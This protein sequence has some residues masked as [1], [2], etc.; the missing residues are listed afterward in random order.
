MLAPRVLENV[1][2]GWNRLFGGGPGTIGPR[3][4]D[5]GWNHGRLES[6]F[7][8]LFLGVYAASD[9][10]SV[11]VERLDGRDPT[12]ITIC[13]TTP[14]GTERIASDIFNREL[15]VYLRTFPNPGPA[16]ISVRLKGVNA[17]QKLEYQ[18]SVEGQPNW[19]QVPTGDDVA[20]MGGQALDDLPACTAEQREDW[21]FVSE[22]MFGVA[23]WHPGGNEIGAAAAKKLGA[24][25]WMPIDGFR[26]TLCGEVA[27]YVHFAGVGYDHGLSREYDLNHFVIP[28]RAFDYLLEFPKQLWQS[29][30]LAGAAFDYVAEGMA[31]VTGGGGHPEMLRGIEQ[32]WDCEGT[33]DCIETEVTANSRFLINPYFDD[34]KSALEGGPL[35]VYGPW[36]TE[37]SHNNRPEIHP[38]ELAWWRETGDHDPVV[39]AMIQD[40]SERYGARSDYEPRE[41]LRRTWIGK[42]QPGEFW[43]A[44]DADPGRPA[45]LTFEDVLSHEVQPFEKASAA[46]RYTMD[47]RLALVVNHGTVQGLE[48]GLAETSCVDRAN[49]RVLG[50]VMARS[51]LGSGTA[52]DDVGFR[53]LRARRH[54]STPGPTG[55]PQSTRESS[56]TTVQALTAS[57]LGVGIEPPSPARLRKVGLVGD[58]LMRRSGALTVDLRSFEGAEPG[59]LRTAVVLGSGA[60][61]GLDLTDLGLPSL[62]LAPRLVQPRPES[63]GHELLRTAPSADGAAP[64]PRIGPRS[65][66]P[67]PVPGGPARTLPGGLRP[68]IDAKSE[69]SEQA[70]A[71]WGRFAGQLVGAADFD[72]GR[73]ERR[74]EATLQVDVGYAARRG[75]GLA[76]EDENAIAE[77]INDEIRNWE[78]ERLR[79]LFGNE[80][81]FDV[82]WEVVVE[83]VAT[84]VRLPVSAAGLPQKARIVRSA[85]ERESQRSVAEQLERHSTRREATVP[86]FQRPGLPRSQP[87]TSSSVRGAAGEGGF[88]DGMVGRVTVAV[89]ADETGPYRII[90]IA[91]VRDPYGNSSEVR[92]VSWS[93]ALIGS[94]AILRDTLERW[95]TSWAPQALDPAAGQAIELT[96]PWASVRSEPAARSRRVLRAML[97]QAG[98]DGEI[99]PGEL[100][101]VVEIVHAVEPN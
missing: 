7:E 27:D 5:E 45:V 3:H 21:R 64:R 31:E 56:A 15:D 77:A 25:N 60:G 71:V 48:V 37:A 57:G 8:R 97:A 66:I 93:H 52:G 30:W 91:R 10:L 26:H 85:L 99:D 28:H 24:R 96:T 81:P 78:P 42:G 94:P 11:A 76:P 44:V 98:V 13:R 74:S 79:S 89:P 2:S 34:E 69:V 9:E 16:V 87:E 22:R 12:W 70:A 39:L 17:V 80:S 62:A 92:Q 95:V 65:P 82:R 1:V 90:T 86:T 18:V 55:Q 53:L 67:T 35:C 49:G 6:L 47:G 46:L 4:L 29:G 23:G 51:R 73:V 41:D 100:T 68:S 75:K 43:I 101:A 40:A 20:L 84:G 59:A 61:A 36:V 32:W 19:P 50:W 88:P 54:A 63:R 38:Y 58:S 14:Q 83:D 72:W 33:D